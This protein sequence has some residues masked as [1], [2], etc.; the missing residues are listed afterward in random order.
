MGADTTPLLRTKLRVPSLRAHTISRAR[1]LSAAPGVSGVRL[2]LACAP[3]GFGKTTCLASWCHER[4]LQHNATVAWVTLDADDNDQARFLAYLAAAVSQALP[5]AAHAMQEALCDLPSAP[6][7]VGLIRLINVLAEVDHEVLL[8]LDDYDAIVT[9]AIHTAV[10]LLLD[11]LPDNVCLAIGS[12]TEPPLP[13]ARLRVRQQLAELRTADLRFTLDEIQTFFQTAG[14]ADLTSEDIHAISTAVEGWP[15]AVQLV[16]LVLSSGHTLPPRTIIERLRDSHPYIFAYLAEEV[17]ER[18]PAEVQHFLLHTAILD[19]L[20][21]P[22]CNAVLEQQESDN[23]TSALCSHRMLTL[24]EHTNL[25]VTVLDGERCWYRYHPLFQ[26]FLQARLAREEA[27]IAIELHRRAS[28]WY[29]QNRLAP[30]GVAHAL[31]AGDITHAST[32]IEATA[33]TMITNG[34]YTTLHSWL[35]QIPDSIVMERPA[36]CMWAAWDALLA[37]E[38]ERIT[39]YLQ[40]AE[41]TWQAQGAQAHLGEIA[42]LR[43]HIAH[44][45]HNPAEML[46]AAQQALAWLPPEEPTLRAGSLLAL[47]IGQLQA[48]DLGA[49]LKTLEAAQ[50]QC[51]AHNGLGLIVTLIALGDHQV[52]RGKLRAATDY[53]EKALQSVGERQL[54]ERWQAEIRLGDIAR[55]QNALDQAL[56]ILQPALTAAEQSGLAIYLPGGYIAL[57][58]TLAARGDSVAAEAAFR[59][60]QHAAERLGATA[61][62]RQI[63]AYRIR[64]ALAGGDITS[65]QCWQEAHTGLLDGDDDSGDQETDEIEALTLARV[66]IA[67]GYGRMGARALSAAQHLLDRCYRRAEEAG[68]IKSLIEIQMLI[69]MVEAGAGHRDQAGQMLRQVLARALPEGY[70]RMFLDAGAPMSALLAECRQQLTMLWSRLEGEVRHK[71]RNA[72]ERLLAATLSEPGIGAGAILPE[73]LSERESEVLAHLAVGESNQEI[74]HTLV[75]GVGTVKS[76]INH[77]LGKLDASNRTEA[78]ARARALQL[79]ED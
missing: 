31:A 35:A 58:R 76:H 67:Q 12:R 16:A 70:M 46:T 62:E 79:L 54:W 51:R 44:L 34:E 27:G 77:I 63:E 13:L 8:V 47:G 11:R 20:S 40:V 64:L 19:R 78:V 69:A 45:R 17:F 48:G 6:I 24:L 1:V 68:R 14:I 49:A 42:H 18:Q 71:M 59:R 29:E 26:E 3:A 7:A 15:A 10:A 66:L 55:E 38:V 21:A 9:P 39:S 74:A 41:H 57:A 2:L 30:L 22:L 60:G 73:R 25:F 56:A 37:G 72:L 33:T 28:A 52:S 36:L 75:I 53:Y 65:S 23:A 61:Y 43:A 4:V 5:N 32:L 50:E